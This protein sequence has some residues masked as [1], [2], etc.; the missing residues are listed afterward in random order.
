M[1]PLKET[2]DKY[3]LKP[4]GVIQTASDEVG[5]TKAVFDNRDAP[6]LNVALGHADT[7]VLQ[8][9]LRQKTGIDVPLE[10]PRLQVDV[11]HQLATFKERIHCRG[12]TFSVGFHFRNASVN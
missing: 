10:K 7:L 6:L 5:T 1:I 3:G 8:T 9:E 2:L 12:V 11:A 4:N